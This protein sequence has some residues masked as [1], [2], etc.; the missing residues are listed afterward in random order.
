MIFGRVVNGVLQAVDLRDGEFCLGFKDKQHV[1][2][3]CFIV[4]FCEIG[5][6]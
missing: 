3:G 6:Q 4:F 5:I 2:D 1:L